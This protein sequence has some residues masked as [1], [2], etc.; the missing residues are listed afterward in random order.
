MNT[1][2]AYPGPPS[3]C[4][5]T[6]LVY[7][8]LK[9]FQAPSYLILASAP[10]LRHL[11]LGMYWLSLT[12]GEPEFD[13]SMSAILPNLQQVDI[14]HFDGSAD[15]VLALLDRCASLR[16]LRLS[17]DQGRLIDDLTSYLLLLELAPSL[18]SLI[19]VIDVPFT[20]TWDRLPQQVI[21]RLRSVGRLPAYA[22]LAE[23]K[24]EG[25]ECANDGTDTEW[26]IFE[27]ECKERGTRASWVSEV[28]YAIEL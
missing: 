25:I 8:I 11:S 20:Q 22:R 15:N 23:W 5:S 26:N 4:L 27:D 12:W 21:G 6:I 7:R 18:T 19:I 17:V 24:F 28:P 16:V 3:F 1:A 9:T 10:T 2:D 14:A 13:L